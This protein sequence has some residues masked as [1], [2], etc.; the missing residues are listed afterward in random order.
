M[1]AVRFA[2]GYQD[3][4]LVAKGWSADRTIARQVKTLQAVHRAGVSV[5]YRPASRDPARSAV[6]YRGDRDPAARWPRPAWSR[7]R[8]RIRAT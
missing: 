2:G 6:L 3:S 4:A 7:R 8:L 1:T 5:Y